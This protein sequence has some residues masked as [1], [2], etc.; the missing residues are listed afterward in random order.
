MSGRT[1]DDND[2]AEIEQW[3][4]GQDSLNAPCSVEETIGVLRE[5]LDVLS[6]LD[7]VD[8]GTLY[9]AAESAQLGQAW[10]TLQVLAGL[11]GRLNQGV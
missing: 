8:V 3:L 11:A 6:V 7:G 4:A 9:A 10:G 1:D 2:L 5:L